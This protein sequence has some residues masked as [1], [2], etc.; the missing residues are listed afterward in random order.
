V[1]RPRT[2]HLAL[3][4][5]A[6]C[7]LIA[8][9]SC[10]VWQPPAVAKPLSEPRSYSA[11][12]VAALMG[13]TAPPATSSDGRATP[14]VALGGSLESGAWA[15]APWTADFTDIEGSVKPAPA[16]RTRVK[17][18]WDE[19]FLYI[20][21]E[22]AEP[23]IWSMLT[24]HDEIVF[25]DNDFE[26]FID[27]NSDTR[28][29]YEIEINARGTVFDLYLHRPYRE[30]APAIHEWNVTGGFSKSVSF[31]GTPD[32]PRDVD[33]SWTVMMAI[34]WKAFMPPSDQ[35]IDALPQDQRTFG[36]R[37]RKGA[38]PKPGDTWSIN[39]SR[40]QWRHNHEVL[41]AAGMRLATPNAAVR[42]AP[43]G[44]EPYAKRAGLPED[45]WVWSPQ[46]AVDMHLPQFWGRVTF[47]R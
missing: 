12:F 32:D 27:P 38:A 47:V 1:N 18:L 13:S 7:A 46:W 4:I 28:E 6:S 20:G 24:T 19:A 14:R 34:P 31:K 21:A 22:L 40:V 45:N 35:R 43:G 26:V 23:D 44:A 42:S 25:H 11:P 39:F 16:Y 36:E 17:M 29:Y 41:D 15:A 33:Q 3:V 8:G 2:A 30:G 37:A 10:A 9:A 5:T